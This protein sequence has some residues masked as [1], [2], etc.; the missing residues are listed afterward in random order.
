MLWGEL[1]LLKKELIPLILSYE[2]KLRK[3]NVK[4]NP[5]IICVGSSGI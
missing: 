2:I 3:F 5:L 4:S 1:N